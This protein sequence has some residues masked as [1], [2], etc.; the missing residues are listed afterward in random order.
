MTVFT[1]RETSSLLISVIPTLIAP[2]SPPLPSLVSDPSVRMADSA[3]T[4]EEGSPTSLPRLHVKATAE[5][6]CHLQAAFL[7]DTHP[8]AET[9]Q[10]LADLTGL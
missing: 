8:T 5:Q 1:L 4:Q 2:T 3:A 9:K 7:A 10:S 6:N